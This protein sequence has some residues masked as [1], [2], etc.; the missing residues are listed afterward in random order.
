MITSSVF[1]TALGLNVQ[2][3]SLLERR[4]DAEQEG[5][6]VDAKP[7]AWSGEK[8]SWPVRTTVNPQ[9]EPGTPPRLDAGTLKVMKREIAFALIEI[10]PSVAPVASM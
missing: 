1:G 2:C 9:P 3:G 4:A 5:W 8:P 7:R 6:G 10:V